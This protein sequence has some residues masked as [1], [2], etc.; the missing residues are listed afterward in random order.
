MY[1]FFVSYSRFDADLAR[2]IG[3]AF[4]YLGV[5]AWVAESQILVEG[6]RNLRDE[7]VLHD[8]IAEAAAAS[9][10]CLVVLSDHAFDHSDWVM[11][12]EIPMFMAR[13]DSEPGPV[14]W[15]VVG[16]EP[17]ED[18]R[19]RWEREISARG[20]RRHAVAPIR[21]RCF[22]PAEGEQAVRDVCRDADVSVIDTPGAAARA[23]A[24][25]TTARFTIN[26]EHRRFNIGIDLGVE[27]TPRRPTAT[28][29]LLNARK[30]DTGMVLNLVVGAM[31][32]SFHPEKGTAHVESAN[33]FAEPFVTRRL[34]VLGL[35][36]Q[37]LWTRLK[38]KAQT[39]AA[40]SQEVL[41]SHVVNVL[42]QPHFAYTYRMQPLLGPSLIAR[43][44]SIILSPPGTDER[45][46]EFV[47]TAG[48]PGDYRDFLTRIPR[49]DTVVR[50][51]RFIS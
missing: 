39:A 2:S 51:L 26:T 42:E 37:G 5:P 19:D 38:L 47:F 30:A 13:A 4:T 49:V 1:E 12:V 29:M 43:K 22:G 44:Y 6:R 41:G 46:F 25:T 50:S 34:S 3:E 20:W 15:P 31:P 35:S 32:P 45:A 8:I 48:C 36:R 21:S 16:S 23:S 11:P 10:R 7:K 17:A 27:W 40:G 24:S 18:V 28:G 33:Y 14:V 9:R